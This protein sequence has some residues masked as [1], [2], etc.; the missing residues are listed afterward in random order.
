MRNFKFDF[1]QFGLTS[2]EK[3]N[4]RIIKQ[5]K[6][7][8]EALENIVIKSEGS[9]L[10]EEFFSEAK[11]EIKIVTDKL[12]LTPNQAILLAIFVENSNDSRIRTTEIADHLGCNN[13]KVLRLSNDIEDLL[14]KRY[15]RSSCND[16]NVF[17]RVPKEVTDALQKD[18]PFIYIKKEVTNI[19][20][21]LD[22]FDELMNERNN[23]EITYKTLV[24]ETEEMLNKIKDSDFVKELKKYK[25]DQDENIIFIF[26]T[27]LLVRDNDNN[28]Q[29]RDL[30]H[31]YGQSIPFNINHGL[32]SKKL[33]LFKNQLIEQQSH[34]G[35]LCP[36]SYRLTQKAKRE[37][38]GDLNIFTTS[39]ADKNLLDPNTLAK[40]SLIYNPKEKTRIEELNYLLTDEQF[41]NVQFNL[42]KSGMRKGFCC[43]FYGDPGTGKTETVYQIAKNTGR[44]IMK[45]DVNKIKASL[46]GE[47]EKNI[48]ELFDRYRNICK[49]SKLK[50]IL[51]FNE[52]DAVLGIRLKGANH[53]VEKMENSIQNI[54]LQ[55]MENLEGIMIATTNLTTNLDSAFERRFIYKIQFNRPTEEAR[56]KIWLTMI[57]DLSNEEASALAH[58]YDFSGGEIENIVRKQTINSILKGSEI[59]NIES[60]DQFCQEEKIVNSRPRIG[61]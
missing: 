27:H 51:L 37:L 19:G 32:R 22:R 48:K 6:T 61:F 5:P 58:K 8:L 34:D 30:S 54:I 42:E 15:I 28:V 18:K 43:L 60:I 26:M 38:L 33:Q 20:E 1:E 14:T 3:R 23:D 7:I 47:S 46:V 29:L 57:P 25:M 59:A 49:N 2:N 10:Q 55:E 17:Y 11:K 44:K 21:F 45:V 39:S 13:I 12:G 35:L 9:N 4:Q 50:P 53:A 56:A 41:N 16:N 52:A 40:K 31:L 24:Q 36:E